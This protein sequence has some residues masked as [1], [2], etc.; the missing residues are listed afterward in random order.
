MGWGGGGAWRLLISVDLSLY[1][2]GASEDS[3]PGVG[4]NSLGR[5]VKSLQAW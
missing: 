5:R 3:G 4:K 2:P 1:S